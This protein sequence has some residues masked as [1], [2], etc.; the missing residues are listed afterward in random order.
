MVAHLDGEFVW[1]RRRHEPLRGFWA[2]PTGYVEW[3]ESTEEAALRE[4]REETGLEVRLDRLLGVYSRADTGILFV[5]YRGEV[6]GGEARA[7]DDAEAVAF[8][9]PTHLPATAGNHRGTQHRGRNQHAQNGAAGHDSQAEFSIVVEAVHL[10][11]SDL[12]RGDGGAAGR[13]RGSR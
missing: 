11:E 3:D 5:A 6:V 8:F 12:R 13:W 10:R 9:A 4:A 1:V 7:S 2:P